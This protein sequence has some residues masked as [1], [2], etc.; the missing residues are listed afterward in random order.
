MNSKSQWGLLLAVIGLTLL[1]LVAVRGDYSGT[2]GQ[3]Q[4]EIQSS[5]PAYRPWAQPLFQPASRE[6]EGLLFAVQA[7][8]GAG[9]IGYVIGRYQER[10]SKRSKQD[11]PNRQ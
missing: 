11:N 1:P 9:V 4:A 3:A 2:D 10:S 6:I 5:H 8:V 7:A